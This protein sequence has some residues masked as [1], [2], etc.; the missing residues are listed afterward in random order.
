MGFGGLGDGVFFYVLS[1][2]CGN[3]CVFRFLLKF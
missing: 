3:F 1:V 2:G